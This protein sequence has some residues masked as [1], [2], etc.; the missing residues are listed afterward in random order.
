VAVWPQGGENARHYHR[1]GRSGRSPAAAHSPGCYNPLM[2]KRLALA[3]CCGIIVDL[4]QHFLA[5]LDEP[6]RANI[7]ASTA[8][9]VRLLGYFRIPIVATR[10][11]PLAGK[12][13]LPRAIERRLRGYDLAETFEK[14]FFDLTKETAIRDHIAGLQKTQ[15][16]VAGCETDVCVLQSCLGLRNLGYQVYLVEDLLFS[17]SRNVDAAIARMRAEGAVPL[18]YKSLTYELLEAVEESRHRKDIAERFGSF[19][20]DLPD[21]AVQ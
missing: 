20:D 16:I 5:Q 19:P 11:R 15:M 1:S 8:N 12:G 14:D 9:L 3:H 21:S 10:E 4:Q 6:L 17:S 2:A 13:A 7:E 18:T